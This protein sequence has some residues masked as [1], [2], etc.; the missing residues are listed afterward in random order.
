[1]PS[2][3]EEA[4]ERARRMSRERRGDERSEPKPVGHAQ[5]SPS[6]PP[7]PPESPEPPKQSQKQPPK[8]K[9]AP[10]AP[11]MIDTLLK[12]KESSLIMILLLLLM[13]EKSDPTLVFSLMY[14]LM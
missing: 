7:E 14:L 4:F 1:M 9:P 5:H 10:P 8:P 11:N 13:D 2:F 12:D 6:G 3:E